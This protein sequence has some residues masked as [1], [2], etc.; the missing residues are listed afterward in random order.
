M[1]F[2]KRVATGPYSFKCCDKFI[3]IGICTFNS[4]TVTEEVLGS[5]KNTVKIKFSIKLKFLRSDVRN[6]D[7]T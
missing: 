5:R 7:P 2:Q 4:E 1:S 3:Y 6:T